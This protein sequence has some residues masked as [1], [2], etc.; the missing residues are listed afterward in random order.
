LPD[1]P[2]PLSKHPEKQNHPAG[3]TQDHESPQFPVSPFQ[4]KQEKHRRTDQTKDPVQNMGHSG[5]L[6][7]KRPQ[8][9]IEKTGR[10]SQQDGL[11]KKKKLL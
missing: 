6:Q 11:R 10:Q 2:Q 7:P 8:Q 3:R 4:N 9:I 1:G 5:Q